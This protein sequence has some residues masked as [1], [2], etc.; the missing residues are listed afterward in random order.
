VDEPVAL[1]DDPGVKALKGLKP[2][3][4]LPSGPPIAPSNGAQLAA[5]SSIHIPPRS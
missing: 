4:K 5:Q 1:P 3:D 2:A